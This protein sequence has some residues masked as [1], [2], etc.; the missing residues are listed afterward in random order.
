MPGGARDAEHEDRV[1]TD[2]GRLFRAID[3]EFRYGRDADW[4]ERGGAPIEEFIAQHPA[5]AVE[6]VAYALPRSRVP[7]AARAHALL[8][9]GRLGTP[10]AVRAIEG[11]QAWAE[12]RGQSPRPAPCDAGDHL[13]ALP[14]PGTRRWVL[15][16]PSQRA[17]GGWPWLTWTDDGIQWAPSELLTDVRDP[18][19]W[20][21]SR[22]DVSEVAAAMRGATRDSALR[23]RIQYIL[24][25]EREISRGCLSGSP[26]YREI[27]AGLSKD[28]AHPERRAIR[29]AAFTVMFATRNSHEPLLVFCQD[30]LAEDNL[31]GYP[32][33]WLTTDCP[34]SG[35]SH[36]VRMHVAPPADA[37][38]TV[39]LERLDG[40]DSQQF[41]VTVECKHGR[42]VATEVARLRGA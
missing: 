1:K 20:H 26:Y 41:D 9:L 34:V 7:A 3:G 28:A 40:R 35:W 22:K 21:G 39:Q 37:R 32:G 10:E 33:L 4:R 42:W 27:P 6:A 19:W 12:G 13:T 15:M 16:W 18:E 31:V 2:T 8:A 11:F 5:T 36:L 38:T 29:Q 23:E 25:R 24:H 17:W 14:G 30:G